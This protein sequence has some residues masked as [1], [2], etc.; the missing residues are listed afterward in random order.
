[1]CIGLKWKRLNAVF[2]VF[3]AVFCLSYGQD[4]N[5]SE[6][7]AGLIP[8][9]DVLTLINGDRV[10]TEADWLQFRKPEIKALFEHLV[11][12]VSPGM[13]D[14][15]IFEIIEKNGKAFGGLGIRRQVNLYF[16]KDRSG[17]VISLLMYLPTGRLPAPVFLG[18]NFYGNQTVAN[19]PAVPVTTSW[20][21]NDMKMGTVN[22]RAAESSRGMESSRWCIEKVLQ[23]GYGIATAYYGDIDP[24]FDDGF[25]NGVHGLF[26]KPDGKVL[27]DAWG[28]I[29]AW[30]WGLSRCMD[31]LVT[32]KDVDKNHVAVMGHS[33]LG[34][35]ALWAGASD[36]RFFMVISNNSGCGG[37]ALS[38]R[39]F[40]ENV[41][42]IN[43]RFPH[44]F[45]GN[46]RNYNNREEKLPVDQHMLIALI[47]PRPVYIASATED[48]WADP[49]GE[50]LSGVLATP[51]YRL[52]GLSGLPAT[53]MPPPDTPVMGTIGYHIRTG[54][55]DI[56]PYDWDQYLKFAD[57]YTKK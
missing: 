27:P 32:D 40:G 16:R 30:A 34:K 12:G 35:A 39:V 5:Y 15:L 19:D 53:E 33:R 55:H 22:N 20:V 43:T 8:V 36:E 49:H 4:I 42:A 54:K 29:A 10:Q 11:Y 6:E 25:Q 28:S 46:F 48:L 2:L 44:W 13:P 23:K 52:F 41:Q 21:S 9:P 51:V 50:F 17:P 56:T 45:C 47:A 14:T 26:R 1:M 38:K 31:Y 3:S 37:A 18:L 57:N 7:K 24:D